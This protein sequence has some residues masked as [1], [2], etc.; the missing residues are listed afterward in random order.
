MPSSVYLTWDTGEGVSRESWSAFCEAHGIMKVGHQ[1]FRIGEIEATMWSVDDN[2]PNPSTIG[3]ITLST[4]WCGSALA[5]L[6]RLAWALW[7][8]HGGK[9]QADLELRHALRSLNEEK[10]G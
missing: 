2:A 5:D 9:M 8:E 10:E 6:A 3:N 4:Y 1:I 7:L